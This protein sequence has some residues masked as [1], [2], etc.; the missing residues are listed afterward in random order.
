MPEEPRIGCRDPE[1]PVG[2][3]M[4]GNVY[5][6]LDGHLEGPLDNALGLP[7]SSILVDGDVPVL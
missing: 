6:Q 1:S 3:D 7:V 5:A 2:D 4:V